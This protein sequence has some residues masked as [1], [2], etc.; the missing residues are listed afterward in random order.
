MIISITQD[1]ALDH[2]ITYAGGL[3]VL[4]GDK[5][6]AMAHR[7]EAYTVLTLYYRHGYVRLQRRNDHLE[8]LPESADPAFLARL[9]P[10]HDLTVILRGETVVVKPLVYRV[11]NARAV[12]FEAVCPEWARNLCQRI[13][14]EA[15]AYERFLKLALLAKAAHTY[16]ESRIGWERVQRV[17][18]QES[19]TALGITSVP[20]EKTGF[21]LHTPGPWGHP[22]FPRSWIQR[23]FDDWIRRGLMPNLDTA[24]DPLNLTEWALQY[25]ARV[26]AVSRKHAEISRRLY[27]VLRHRIRAA[28]N[29]VYLPRWQHPEIARA[30]RAGDLERF[31]AVRQEL[32]REIR[33][34]LH[35][36]ETRGPIVVWTR[37]LTRYKRPY[38][39][40]RFIERHPDTPAVFLLGGRPHPHDRDGIE[41]AHR[42][43]HLALR[44][45]MV[46]VLQH[47]DL[48][49]A[50]FVIPRGE[51]FLFT[52]FSGWEACGTSFMKAG[53]NG[54]PTLSAR[55]GGTLEMIRHGY[56]GWFFGRE[57]DT[58]LDIYHDPAAR[59]IDENDYADFERQML[60]I[61]E[62]YMNDPTS[63]YRIAFA[64]ARS[65]SEHAD[66][67]RTLRALYGPEIN[68]T[69][70]ST[71]KT[72]APG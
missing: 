16:I 25:A 28:T 8:L 57:M 18:F 67:V 58:L 48:E 54:V 41:A 3:G 42:F 50:R 1:F 33:A 70:E 26:F 13:Y 60:A 52:P 20:R 61:I 9:H 51:V 21:V 27:P 34:S 63:Y 45:P 66:I 17:D 68:G 55:D 15:D 62:L 12:F 53:I 69:M 40:C 59:E 10:E 39:V 43:F 24:S 72:D 49:A 36:P 71:A 37:R 30:V 14:I 23:E 38:F 22:T 65:F 5:F 46:H 2:S 6:Y 56:N 32:R 7:G 47:Y 29:G 35:L 64:A 11:H 4:E 31:I 19:S 44:Y